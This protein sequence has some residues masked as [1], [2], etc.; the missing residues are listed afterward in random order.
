MCFWYGVLMFM[1]LNEQKQVVFVRLFVCVFVLRARRALATGCAH[2]D[3]IFKSH[4]IN[5]TRILN[6]LSN[7]L[8]M[9]SDGSSIPITRRKK[10][11]Y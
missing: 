3:L 6:Y 7:S 2:N 9:L 11:D 8:V 10:E 4:L 5:S 1:D